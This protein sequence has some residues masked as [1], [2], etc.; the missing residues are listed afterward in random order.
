MRLSLNRS[1]EE[2]SGAGPTDRP[3]TFPVHERS[4]LRIAIIFERSMLHTVKIRDLNFCQEPLG[5]KGGN[6]G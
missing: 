1:Q 6:N 4:S 2:R 3:C 5:I